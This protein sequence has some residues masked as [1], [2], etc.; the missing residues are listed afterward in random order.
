MIYFVNEYLMALNSGIEHAEIKRLQLFKH[1]GT[2]AKLVTRNFDQMLYANKQRFGIEDDQVVNMYDYFQGIEDLKPVGKNEPKIES[3]NLAADYNVD[4]GADVSHV[5]DGDKLV[6]NVHFAPG[7]IGQLYSVDAFD[8]SGKKVQTELWDFRGFKTRDQFF[9]DAGELISQVTYAP[10]GK[11]VIEEYFSHDKDGHNFLSLLQLLDYKGQDLFFDSYDEL[12]TFFL[13]ELNRRD[14]EG[15]TF[16]ADRPGAAY[17]AML[18]MTTKVSR[19]ITLPTTHTIDP[20]DQ[21]YANLSGIYANP[22]VNQI[23]KLSGIIVA[24]DEQKADLTRWMGGEAQVKAPITVV[25]FSVVNDEQAHAKR[26]RLPQ[27]TA[28]KVIVVGRLTKERHTEDVVKAFVTVKKHISDATLDIYGYGDQEKPLT[29][30]IKKAELTDSVTLKG[31]HPD[32]DKAYDGAQVYVNATES[33]NE[34]LALAEALAHGVPSV[35]YNVH[36]GPSDM[37][38]EGKNGYLVADNDVVGLANA[39]QRV[40]K[41]DQVWE[42]MSRNA[43]DSITPRTESIVFAKWKRALHIKH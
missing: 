36:Y 28:H 13:D 43:Y 22:I 33:D 40:M 9:S 4:P 10:D 23:D 20:K 34:P 6:M 16:V 5:Y 30:Q 14:G 29:E 27:R 42:A 11:R 37:I 39:I 32:L 31:Y 2:P 19:F 24:T 25:P 18:S 26:V 15:S 1:Q 17:D 7:T 41:D 35:V 38:D 21:V 3:L 12:F 8:R